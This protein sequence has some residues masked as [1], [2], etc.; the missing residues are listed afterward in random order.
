MLFKDIAKEFKKI[1]FIGIGGIGMSAIAKILHEIGLEVQGSDLHYSNNIQDLERNSIK[2]FIGHDSSN[3]DGNIDLVV[4]SSIIKPDN[5]EF[6][7]AKEKSIK[8]I[9]RAD[10]LAKIMASKKGVTIAGTHGKTSTTAMVGV[11]LEIAKM[12]PT[13]I[14]GGI[15][16]YYN[17]N[18]K[19]GKGNFLVAES[20]ESDAS[21]VKLPTFIG[22]I[23]NIEA[24][25]L[26]YYGGNFQIVKDYYLQYSKQIPQNGLLALGIDN[27]EV[28]NLYNKIKDQ[29]NIITFG[30]T[31]EADIVAQNLTYNADGI[32]FDVL[33]KKNLKLIKSIFLPLYGKHNVLNSLVAIAVANYLG[34]E[35]S[36]IKKAFLSFK[37][38]KKRFTKIG[39]VN[40]V[41]IIDDYAHHPTEIKAT[42][43]AAKNIVKNNKIIAIFQPH[44]HS[45]IRDLFNE[46]SESFSDADIVIVSDIYRVGQEI[47]GINK[48]SLISEIVS[49]SNK[50]VI[51]LNN[52]DELPAIIKSNSKKGDIVIFM[53]A[54]DITLWANEIINKL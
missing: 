51:A 44:K 42:L 3:I 21:F 6:L 10:M 8:V 11:L 24:E 5:E 49:R 22:A 37:G 45:R 39:E 30:F 12:D 38:V 2:C 15:I 9:S 35:E 41:T 4:I 32:I 33:I 40:G 7:A 29:P 19:L 20:D 16:N 1:H 13:I 17:S 26:E 23:T 46:F 52:K 31:S 18:S 47:K 14:N 25:H 34:L 53:G 50:N 54:G 36:L 43:E 28:A 48:E 27:E